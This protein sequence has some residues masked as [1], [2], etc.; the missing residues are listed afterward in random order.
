M[1]TACVKAVFAAVVTACYLPTDDFATQVKKTMV[2]A[3]LVASVVQIISIVVNLSPAIRVGEYGYVAYGVVNATTG[4]FLAIP[5]YIVQRTTRSIGDL[6]FAT[7]IAARFV[8]LTINA[9]SLPHNSNLVSFVGIIVIASLTEMRLRPLC[10]FLGIVG[11]ALTTINDTSALLFLPIVLKSTISSYSVSPLVFQVIINVAVVVCVGG[12][13]DY[14]IV[15]FNQTIA[16]IEASA[17]LA[18][19]VSQLFSKYDTDA[20]EAVLN[21]YAESPD[22]DRRQ[23][24]ASRQLLMNLCRYRPYL[25]NYVLP[26]DHDSV[27]SVPDTDEGTGRLASNRDDGSTLINSERARAAGGSAR[28]KVL[29]QPTAAPKQQTFAA[30]VAESEISERISID[31][32]RRS[33]SSGDGVGELER[34]QWHLAAAPSVI[35]QGKITMCQ[36]HAT[37]DS[38]MPPSLQRRHYD[39]IT[40]LIFDV[41]TQYNASVHTWIGDVIT[42]TWN[43]T[44][45][46]NRPEVKACRFALQLLAAEPPTFQEFSSY[47]DT[48]S[49]TPITDV[50]VPVDASASDHSNVAVMVTPAGRRSSLAAVPRDNI[51]SAAA[52]SPGPVFHLSAVV[53]T[54][55]CCAFFAG[56]TTKLFVMTDFSDSM[57]Q[58]LATLDVIVRDSG[59]RIVVDAF[60]AQAVQVDVVARAI[61]FD[62]GGGRAVTEQKFTSSVAALPDA[63]LKRRLVFEVLLDRHSNSHQQLEWMYALQQHEG[64]V[65]AAEAVTQAALLHLKGHSAAALEAL[66]KLIQSTCSGN[67]FGAQ[68]QNS[69]QLSDSASKT[70]L[71]P[72]ASPSTNF[73]PL[74]YLRSSIFAS[75]RSVSAGM[76]IKGG[77]NLTPQV[78]PHTVVDSS[79]AS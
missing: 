27:G 1:A 72:K 28:D 4:L 38:R 5:C 36:L 3:H 25:P 76:D 68:P 79:C 18:L 24:V 23:L 58:R 53:C 49:F 70:E 54:G 66:D 39:R 17:A 15:R 51:T 59:A 56:T 74:Q 50:I 29:E 2:I 9:V 46:S 41:G 60:T 30:A 64:T 20:V 45:K 8:A 32:T 40:A 13:A 48:S 47:D 26:R 14:T 35:S 19:E 63:V 67:P 22:V 33:A 75:L 57:E 16:R 77:D 21:A 34:L 11:V 55:S 10:W 73:R 52:A 43:A 42:L 69:S 44:V 61:G 65:D 71:S 31:T 62:A 12:A 37:R 78:M 6:T 7:S